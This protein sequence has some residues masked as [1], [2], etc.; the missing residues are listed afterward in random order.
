MK[1]EKIKKA[2]RIW[3]FGGTGSGKTTLASKLSEKLKI[4]FYTTDMMIYHKGWKKKYSEK[5]RDELMK[6]ISRKNKW[7][8]EGVHRGDWIFP[9]ISRADFFIL[10]D[11]PK[12]IL[13]K[14]ALTR[15]FKRLLNKEVE[16]GKE[17]LRATMQL[18]KYAWIYKKDNRISHLNF[19]SKY[20]KDFI[21]FR[22]QRQINRFIKN[23]R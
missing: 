3:I 5:K 15:Y 9:G 2:K 19:I 22:S 7:I 1:T 12:R 14:R 13:V 17:G 18:L 11:L 4:P 10:I 8:I 16:I 6:T 20:G 21:I 23:L